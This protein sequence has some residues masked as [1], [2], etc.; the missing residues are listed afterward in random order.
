MFQHEDL[1]VAAGLHEPGSG[2]GEFDRGPMIRADVR[3]QGSTV[4]T[5][6]EGAL[7]T[8]A[9]TGPTPRAL[10]LMPS[11][12]EQRAR[13]ERR[14]PEGVH[15]G[16][17]DGWTLVSRQL[18]GAGAVV[19]AV[20]GESVAGTV[21]SVEAVFA[22]ALRAGPVA[23]TAEERR[24]LIRAGNHMVL[25][26]AVTGLARGR[27]AGTPGTMVRGFDCEC[28]AP[29]CEE[30]VALPVADVLDSFVRA[31]AAIVAAGH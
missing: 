20:D 7:V 25:S 22:D 5:V 14:H 8:P 13:L 10:W 24:A 16:Y 31:A 29:G 17:V 6:V 19:L 26:H 11:A 2:P 28:A 15:Q 23:R 9:M 12:A 21:K 1:A 27:A 30:I 4:L 3:A 18:E